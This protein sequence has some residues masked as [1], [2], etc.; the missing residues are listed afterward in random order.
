M[1]YR[2]MPGP[3]VVQAL[4]ELLSLRSPIASSHIRRGRGPIS[5]HVDGKPV[6]GRAAT[7][8]PMTW[9]LPRGCDCCLLSSPAPASCPHPKL[10]RSQPIHP[11]TPHSSSELCCCASTRL[12]KTF[13]D[14]R[15]PPS[16]DRPPPLRVTT[17]QFQSPYTN[18]SVPEA[19]VCTPRRSGLRYSL[20]TLSSPVYAVFS[21]HLWKTTH[22]SS[23]STHPVCLAILP[24]LA[25]PP[26][27][28]QLQHHPKPET[29]KKR[30]QFFPRAPD[31]HRPLAWHG[32][33]SVVT[34][35]QPP[36]GQ[37]ANPR[38]SR[39]RPDTVRPHSRFPKLGHVSTAHFPPT[40]TSTL[41][42]APPHHVPVSPLLSLEQ[43]NIFPRLA[44]SSI[45]PLDLLSTIARRPLPL[46]VSSSHRQALDALITRNTSRMSN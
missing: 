16:S 25:V 4:C 46:L 30:A 39:H 31:N 28:Q 11:W 35:I 41:S 18:P 12:S 27:A 29:A 21:L 1:F 9:P 22:C 45:P 37:F 40:T 34:S 5:R 24:I 19:L 15:H 26:A 33:V 14:L 2:W 13:I 38:A 3:V 32:T 10:E 20:T 23:S 36:A 42:Y 43:N 7:G 6:R 17:T 8:P 44:S